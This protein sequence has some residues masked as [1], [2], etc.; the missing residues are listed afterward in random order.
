MAEILQEI[1][2]HVRCVVERRRREVP[3]EALRE[4]PLFS[5]ARR[6]FA[7]CFRGNQRKIIAEI[8]KASPSKGLI[9]ADFDP[10]A[11]ARDYAAHGATAISV[12]TE[13]HFFQGSLNYLEQI[14][15]VIDVPLLRKDF[16]LDAYQL[17]EAKAY[18]AD[19]V[20]FIAAMLDAGLMRELRAQATE[21]SLDSLVEVHNEQELAAA[22][23]AGANLIGI[24]NRNLKTF[25][26]SLATTE[27]LAPLIPPGMS[28][29]CES[30]I[31]GLEQIR[32]VEK[33]GIHAFLIGE[34][35]MRAPE[36]GNKLTELLKA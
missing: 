11:I 22:I 23:K 27:Q 31:D 3:L 4:R 33:L 6:E 18:G 13:E 17:V 2:E 14:R 34:S 28:A 36:P 7:R 21:L 15:N 25:E 12:L 26:V 16:M 35:L 24:N 8:K 1:A 19:A 5:V 32:R 9:R 29:V 30:G 10:L 20:L